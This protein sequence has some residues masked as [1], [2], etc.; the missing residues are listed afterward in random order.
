MFSNVTR[1]SSWRW[2]I[3]SE[4]PR[5]LHRD[6]RLGGEVL[7]QRDLLVG[8]RPHLLAIDSD[9]AEQDVVLAQRHSEHGC[10][11]RRDRPDR[12][13]DRVAGR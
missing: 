13:I 8:E 11:S 1:S 2:R 4:Q 3:S 9:V 5:I 6:H 10:D 7:Q 12:A